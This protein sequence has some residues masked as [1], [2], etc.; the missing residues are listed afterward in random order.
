[1]A[2]DEQVV[3]GVQFLVSAAGEF[4]HGDEGAVGDAGSGMFPGFANVDEAD[5]GRSFRVFAAFFEELCGCGC[6]DFVI[7]HSF[8]DTWPGSEIRG[9]LWDKRCEVRNLTSA[10]VI[11]RYTNL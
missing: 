11:E 7:Q 2:E 8:Q 5:F 1:M 9:R 3:V 6:G 10:I 4:A